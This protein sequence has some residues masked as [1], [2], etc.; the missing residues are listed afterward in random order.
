MARSGPPVAGGFGALRATLH[1]LRRETGLVRGSKVLVRVNQTQGFDCPGCA[2]PEPAERS[3]F[4]FC[5]NG[6]KAVAEEATTR[7]ASPERI[8]ALTLSQ[9]R[10]L[11]DFELGQLGRLTH[12]M[13]TEGNR[14][15]ACSWDEAFAAIA[16]ALDRL[17]SPDQAVFYTSGR[18]SNEAAFLWQLFARALGTNNLPDCSNMCHESSGVGMA[19]VLGT[20]KGTVSLDDFERADLILVIGQNPGTN[21]PRMLTTLREAAARGC[22]IVSINPLREAG[23]VRFAHPQKPLDFLTGGRPLASD[24]LPVRIGGDVA[25][26]QGLGKAVLEEE[27]RRRGEV[28]DRAFI[29]AHT[30]GF[31]QYASALRS[32][33]WARIVEESGVPEEDIRRVAALYAGAE[34][35][36]ACWAMGITQHVNAVANVQEI[37]NLMLLRGNVGRPGAGLCPVRG[38]SNVQ[39]DRTV[40]ITSS[41][42]PAFLDR[43]EAAFPGLSSPREPG[44]DTVGAIEAMLA[45]RARVFVSMGGNFLSAAPDTERTA[46]A[47]E[48]CALTAHVATKLNRSHVHPGAL[49]LVLPCLGRT[50]IDEQ[51]HGEQMVTVEDSMSM[52]HGSRGFLEPASR[53]LRSE[54]AIVAGIARAALGRRVPIDWDGLIADYDRIREKIAQ[55][56]PGMEE[57]NL[58]VRDGGSFR[59]PNP[60]R[61]RSFP[62]ATGR[63]RFTVHELPRLALP[64][65]ALRLMTV[66]SHDQYNTTIYGLDDRYRGVRGDRR[67]VFVHPAD[68]EAQGLE[69]DQVVDLVGEPGPDGTERRAEAFRVRPYEVPRGCAAAYFPEANALVP[70]ESRAHGSRTPASK[71]VIMRIVTRK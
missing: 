38:H 48:G 40:G 27:H 60:A 25:L 14:Y 36:I 64:P 5:E 71:S 12:P 63:A 44:L 6:A 57:V 70:L 8:G 51:A 50:E 4:E 45:G 26:F 9:L 28:L 13:M 7:R 3:M 24:F 29:A 21:H 17:E 62:T 19:E 2:W 39:G 35:V 37:A 32:R 33:P 43:L 31:A 23:L 49:G 55:V 47:L 59:L 56:V 58:R 18:T 53:E 15:R 11:S 52:V 10:H 22:A 41:P 16:R 30:S 46:G 54:P 66:R 61:E 68:I 65:G 34:R 20:G 67:V 1:H 42:K 69:A